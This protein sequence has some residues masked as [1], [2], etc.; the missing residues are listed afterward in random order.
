MYFVNSLSSGIFAISEGVIGVPIKAVTL[1]PR[2][3]DIMRGKST[4]RRRGWT[5]PAHWKKRGLRPMKCIG[6]MVAPVLRAMAAIVVDQGGSRTMRLFKSTLET[7]PA[8]KA[9]KM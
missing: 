8:G 1:C 3:L 5:T 4:V 2:N 9:P 7:S 6:T